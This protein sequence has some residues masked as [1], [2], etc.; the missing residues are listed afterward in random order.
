[1]VLGSDEEI[2]VNHERFRRKTIGTKQL[3]TRRHQT[4]NYMNLAS[5]KSK[6]AGFILLVTL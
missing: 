3:E 1:M 5:I 6:L 4:Q 2:S